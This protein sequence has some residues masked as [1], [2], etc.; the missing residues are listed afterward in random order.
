[1]RRYYAGALSLMIITCVAAEDLKVGYPNTCPVYGLIRP[2]TVIRITS[3]PHNALPTPPPP[4]DDLGGVVVTS[5]GRRILPT[6]MPS[7]P[8]HQSIPG[9]EFERTSL[10]QDFLSYE[11]ATAQYKL[12]KKWTFDQITSGLSNLGWGNPIFTTGRDDIA[13]Y[14]VENKIKAPESMYAYHGTSSTNYDSILT[15]GLNNLKGQE[16]HAGGAMGRTVV[17]YAGDAQHA[18]SFADTAAAQSGGRPMLLRFPL[19]KLLGRQIP[20]SALATLTQPVSARSL[21]YSIDGGQTWYSYERRPPPFM[22]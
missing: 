18:Q 20:K 14:L 3:M 12:Q 5:G 21:E 19:G 10:D 17:T 22:H 8:V 13:A 9:L 15:H 16:V 4:D 7:R 2:R 11:D 1:M 6:N